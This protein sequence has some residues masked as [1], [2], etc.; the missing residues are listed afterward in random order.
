M[1]LRSRLVAK[2]DEERKEAARQ[3][4]NTQVTANDRSDKI[5]SWNFSQVHHI[6]DNGLLR[7]VL[8]IIEVLNSM[9][10]R[11]VWKAIPWKS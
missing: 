4:R 11:A 2:R 10:S 8:L 6:F 3:L 9:I 5:R 1:I 7:T